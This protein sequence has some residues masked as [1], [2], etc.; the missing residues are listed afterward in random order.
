MKKAL[1]ILMAMAFVLGMSSI[2]FAAPPAVVT[3][4]P[5]ATPTAGAFYGNPA[6]DTT[7]NSIDGQSNWAYKD[8][9]DTTFPNGNASKYEGSYLK[10]QHTDG[11]VTT[12]DGST[13][14]G[15][16]YYQ[17][18]AD[19]GTTTS[20]G[21]MRGPHG[22]YATTSNKCKTCHGVHR[23]DG[24]YELLRSDDPDSACDYCHV[25][26]AIHSIRA[27]YYRS[28]S[29]KYTS[30]GHTIGSGPEIPDSSVWQWQEVRTIASANGSSIQIKARAY[31]PAENKIFKTG[32][33]GG[34]KRVGPYLL[35]CQTC[36]SVH[37]GSQLTWKPGSDT[38]GYMLLRNSPSGSCDSYTAMTQ[39]KGVTFT[40]HGATTPNLA[41]VLVP[42][43][44]MTSGN[45]GGLTTS[46]GKEG[47]S[48][49]FT[50]W[51][52]W[53]G[54]D[55]GV[56]DGAHLAVWCADCHNLNIGYPVKDL[57]Q[58]ANNTLFGKYS[59]VDRTHPVPYMQAGTGANSAPDCY[60]C[61]VTDMY[62]ATASRCGNKCHITPNGYKGMRAKSD[63]PHSGDEG[64]TKLLGDMP[65]GAGIA[66]YVMPD[67]TTTDT[68]FTYGTDESGNP[69]TSAYDKTT[70][71]IDSVCLRCHAEDVGVTQ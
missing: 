51:T 33:H 5:V 28:T 43:T 25:G 66:S 56:N 71:Q 65:A 32:G 42:E 52:Q 58:G 12:A 50:L 15:A 20:T 31:N 41:Q 11:P 19:E 70:E 4:T 59:H 35:Q 46:T 39:Y 7:Y 17:G 45:T 29:G 69:I 21:T 13:Q 22:D 23:A 60:S 49:V 27:A 24:I 61:H 64:S 2:A 44:T 8:N 47:T 53:Q 6:T 62:P 68:P 54:P 57:G 1:I 55:T 67:G 63:F 10:F 38:S 3:T 14:T 37:N 30:N 40:S 36:H 34:L 9:Y 16:G 26:S 48:T 18:F